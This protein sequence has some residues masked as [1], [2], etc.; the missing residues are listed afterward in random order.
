[1]FVPLHRTTTSRL[2]HSSQVS[3]EFSCPECGYRARFIRDSEDGT[4]RLEILDI[5]DPS[6]RHTSATI[7][8]A[9]DNVLQPGIEEDE[10]DPTETGDDL[11]L[12]SC[13]TPASQKRLEEILRGLE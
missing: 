1:M 7:P 11:D 4:S 5:G 12:F 2:E 8:D 6:V 10:D 9:V 3:W 13:L